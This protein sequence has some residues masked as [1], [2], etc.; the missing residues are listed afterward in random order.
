MGEGLQTTPCRSCGAP[1][2]VVRDGTRIE[3]YNADGSEHYYSI[4]GGNLPAVKQPEAIDPKIIES[5]V[6]QGDMSRLSP[7]QKVAYVRYR[8]QAAGLDPDTAPFDIL[9]LNGKEQLYAPKRA[10]D[11]LNSKHGIALKILSQV[12]EGDLRIVTVNARTRDGRETEEVGAVNI[13]GQSGE[14]LANAFMKAV[15]KAKRRATLSVCG[16]GM[17][18]ETEVETIKGAEIVPISS[19]V[20]LQSG[21]GQGVAAP[22]PGPGGPGSTA[23]SPAPAA[24]NAPDAPQGPAKASEPQATPKAKRT[25]R[26]RAGPDSSE[27]SQPEVPADEA[28]PAGVVPAAGQGAPLPPGN[29]YGDIPFDPPRPAEPA[30]T[31]NLQVAMKPADWEL[32]A[33]TLPQIDST[34]TWKDAAEQS[35]TARTLLMIVRAAQERSPHRP[36]IKT[37]DDAGWSVDEIRSYVALHLFNKQVLAS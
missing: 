36:N 20:P 4:P 9:K 34:M 11:Q 29:P 5:L 15:T 22:V 10:T 17:L 12:T 1:V 28:V 24:S 8:A 16:L 33:C 32:G 3:S 27:L 7:M 13:K 30:P 19:Q 26:K 21:A 35:G 18:D 37:G 6:L 31:S 2:A 14:N 23:S 25:I